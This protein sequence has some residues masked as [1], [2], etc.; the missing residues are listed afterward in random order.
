MLA[1]AVGE[2]AFFGCRVRL[3]QMLLNPVMN[4][5]QAMSGLAEERRLL[6]I[7]GQRGGLARGPAVRI[8]VQD[9]GSDTN[10]TI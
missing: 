8:S 9:L 4:G 10:R 1:L 5:I 2:L 7:G 6:T 3:Q